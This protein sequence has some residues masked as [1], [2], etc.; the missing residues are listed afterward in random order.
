ME[1]SFVGTRS[2]EVAAMRL[3]FDQISFMC[4]PVVL[5]FIKTSTSAET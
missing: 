5:L 2:I 1:V 3:K 4:V